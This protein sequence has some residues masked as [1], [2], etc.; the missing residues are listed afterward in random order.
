MHIGFFTASLQSFGSGQESPPEPPAESPLPRLGLFEQ[1]SRGRGG[2]LREDAHQLLEGEEQREAVADSPTVD[3]GRLMKGRTADRHET[4]QGD[5]GSLRSPDFRFTSLRPHTLTEETP[6][7][8]SFD[9]S[10]PQD[11]QGR[12]VSYQSPDWLQ[13]DEPVDPQTHSEKKYSKPW[14]TAAVANDSTEQQLDTSILLQHE[15]PAAVDRHPPI[16]AAA[17]PDTAEDYPAYQ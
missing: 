1:S 12:P 4:F 5:L 10:S 7:S 13:T 14:P 11:L 16:E 9:E 8:E 3:F 2:R 15:P 17:L 6:R